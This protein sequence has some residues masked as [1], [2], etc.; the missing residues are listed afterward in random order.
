MYT[1]FAFQHF[2]HHFSK[3][4]Y[5]HYCSVLDCVTECS[6]SAAHLWLT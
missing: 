1:Y 4:E 6:Q 5:Y 3:M 2:L